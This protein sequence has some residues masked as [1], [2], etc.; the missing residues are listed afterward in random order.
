[1]LSIC[2]KCHCNCINGDFYGF[3]CNTDYD[4]ESHCKRLEQ[5]FIFNNV[6]ETKKVTLFIT[7]LGPVANGILKDLLC[8]VEPSRKT[9]KDLKGK[10][11]KHLKPCKSVIA[12]RCRF[13]KCHQS[14]NE[15]ISDL[16]IKLKKMS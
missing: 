16:I 15:S 2:N 1:M 6:V 3:S 4:F 7:C 8:P 9:Y 14:D 12:E 13:W 5:L 11:L 10:L